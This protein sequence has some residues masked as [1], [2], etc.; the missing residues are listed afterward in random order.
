MQS[1]INAGRVGASSLVWRA[2]WPEWRSA[3]AT[4]P[5][6]AR[7]LASPEVAIFP[8]QGSESSQGHSPI[9]LANGMVMPVG[10]ALPKGQVVESVAAGM[11]QLLRPAEPVSVIPK[12]DN[13]VRR[14]RHK[15]DMSIIYSS[16]LAVV[17]IILVIWLVL[18]FS[19]QNASDEKKP[20]SHHEVSLIRWTA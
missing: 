6:L 1:W 10:S 15:T 17:S 9:P 18:L 14:R 3:A 5:Q 20:E 13:P 16:I 12:L 11:P 4:F 19:N 7:L 8:S 2:G